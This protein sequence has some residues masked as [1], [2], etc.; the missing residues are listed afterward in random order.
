MSSLTNILIGTTVGAAVIGAITYVAK[1]SRVSAQLESVATAMIHSVSLKGLVIRVDITLKNPT[2]TV[3][4]IKYPFIKLLYKESTIGTS[5]SINQDIIIPANG[6][7]HIN[8]IMISVPIT[9]LFSLSSGLLNLLTKK[10]AVVIV[11]KTISTIDLGWRKIPYEK[12]DSINLKPKA[13]NGTNN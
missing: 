7:A 11:V 8:S 5:K 4:K 10:Q 6:E 1:L 2:G 13:Q 9:G 12:T 3:L